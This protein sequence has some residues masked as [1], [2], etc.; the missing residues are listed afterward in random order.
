MPESIQEDDLMKVME[1][2]D[3]SLRGSGQGAKA[4]GVYSLHEVSQCTV[5]FVYMKLTSSSF[6]WIGWDRCSKRAQGESIY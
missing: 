4:P 5:K 1:T 3:K 2:I 6:S